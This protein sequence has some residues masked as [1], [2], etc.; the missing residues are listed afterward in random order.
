MSM[1]LQSISFF[2]QPQR[3]GTERSYLLR[4]LAHTGNNIAAAARVANISRR[5]LYGMIDRLR[6][7][8]RRDDD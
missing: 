3:Q 5:G 1:D 7:E 4:L 6:I 2:I 8:V